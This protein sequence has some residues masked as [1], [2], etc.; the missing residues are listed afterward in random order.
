MEMSSAASGSST[1]KRVPTGRFSSTRI[2]P[3][4]SSMMRLTMARPE[5]GASFLGREVGQEE[6]LFQF[7]GDAMAGVGHRDFDRIAAGN[8]RG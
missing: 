6:S 1:T 7:L 4:W 2:D 8:Q 5:P 3:R